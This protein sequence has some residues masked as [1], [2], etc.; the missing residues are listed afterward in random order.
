MDYLNVFLSGSPLFLQIIDL[1]IKINSMH[2][3]RAWGVSAYYPV[4]F[5]INRSVQRTLGPKLF[6][7]VCLCIM[8]FP[9]SLL[10]FFPLLS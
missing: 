5:F 7:S 8:V 6:V 9:F 4:H 10:G 2:K 1:N 3:S